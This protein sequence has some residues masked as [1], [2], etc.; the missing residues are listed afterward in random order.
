M[1]AGLRRGRRG[2]AASGSQLVSELG[3]HAPTANSMDATSDRDFVLEFVNALSLLGIHLS[4]WAE[5]FILFATQE[6]GFIRCRKRTPPAAAP[7]RKSRI[8]MRWN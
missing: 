7:C 6:Y 8:R 5:E 4:R 2:H 3:F 1:P